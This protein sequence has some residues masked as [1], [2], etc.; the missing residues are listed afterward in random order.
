MTVSPKAQR[1]SA[2]HKLFGGQVRFYRK[3]KGLSL[4]ELAD[5]V[6][7][8]SSLIHAIE[9]GRRPALSP[10][11]EDLDRELDTGGALSVAAESLLGEKVVAEFFADTAEWEKDCV[12]VDSYQNALLPGML[13]T[14]E[15]ARA[16][17]G[18]G[19]P[20]LEDDEIEAQAHG[21]LDRQKLLTRRP[22]A[23][24]SYVIEQA[25]LD[26]PIGGRDV[27]RAQLRRLLELGA[28]RNVSIQIMPTSCQEHVGLDGPMLLLEMP[29]G[30]HH[31]YIESQAGGEAIADPDQIRILRQRYGIIRAQALTIADSRVLIEKLAGEV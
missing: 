22:T 23:L 21:R 11:L 5:A 7:Q 25:V 17:L 26:R 27:L 2:A 4:Q 13:Q 18:V 30:K 29:D 14:E 1:V 9:C 15:Y 12:S 24:C 19:C 16:V 28:M 6:G 10:L 20:P 3:K 31:A 8:S